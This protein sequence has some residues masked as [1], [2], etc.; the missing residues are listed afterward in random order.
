MSLLASTRALRHAAARAVATTGSRV[1]ATTTNTLP[2]LTPSTSPTERSNDTNKDPA[3]TEG[4]KKKK[5]L[6]FGNRGPSLQ[7]FLNASN[8]RSLDSNAVKLDDTM[9]DDTPYLSVKGPRLGAG[10][11]YFVE[12]YGCQMNVNDTEILMSIMNSAGYVKAD[13]QDEADIVFLV[14]CAIRENAEAKIWNRLAELKRRKLGPMKDKAPLV[15]VLGVSP[16]SK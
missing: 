5:H 15:G 12:V 1:L 11:K 8:L 3:S 14:T 6:I 16:Y 4:P 9:L 10:A 13:G 7:D 2:P